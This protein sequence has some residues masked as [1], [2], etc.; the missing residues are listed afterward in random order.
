MWTYEEIEQINPPGKG[1]RA[2]ILSHLIK[3]GAAW[4]SLLCETSN[5]LEE[6]GSPWVCC[7]AQIP[8]PITVE[9]GKYVLRGQSANAV[10]HLDFR[11]FAIEIDQTFQI[12]VSEI[13][14]TDISSY[15]DATVVTQVRGF[16]QLWGR[17]VLYYDNYLSCLD[18]NGLKDQI[19]NPRKSE[20]VVT[21]GLYK[22]KTMTSSVFEGEVSDRLRPELLFAIKRFLPNYSIVSLHEMPPVHN[23]LNYFLMSAPGRVAY[24]ESPIPLLPAILRTVPPNQLRPISKHQIDR[25][26]QFSLREIDK[27][28]HLLLAMH[29]LANDGETELALIGCV[30]AIE[31]YMNSFLPPKDNWQASLRECLK[32]EPF[33]SLPEKLKQDLRNIALI[34]NEFVHGQP[35]DRNNSQTS[36]ASTS[37]SRINIKN[38]VETGLELYRELNFRRTKQ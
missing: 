37:K 35:P 36:N 11:L 25:A 20:W 9:S 2:S 19:I 3:I 23:A 14:P 10:I 30:M 13:K 33:K 7:F 31:W 22:G 32:E 38:V 27:Y 1:Q 4:S 16:I 18:S 15:R 5:D 12:R 6:L 29:R 28:L 21:S 24:G 26:L 8:Y 34:R 17:R